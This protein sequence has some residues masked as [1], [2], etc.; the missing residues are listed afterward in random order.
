MTISRYKAVRLGALHY[1]AV[2]TNTSEG[3]RTALSPAS[4]PK[5]SPLAPRHAE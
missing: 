1:G 2:R 5:G 3:Q 4:D